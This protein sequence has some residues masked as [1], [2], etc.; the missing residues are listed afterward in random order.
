[1]IQNLIWDKCGTDISI[2][3]FFCDINP[4]CF[5]GHEAHDK[6]DFPCYMVVLTSTVSAGQACENNSSYST[7]DN[8][9]QHKK[10]GLPRIGDAPI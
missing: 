10:G 6:S 1:M 4:Y 8:Q 7:I 2:E 3:K 5:I 9:I